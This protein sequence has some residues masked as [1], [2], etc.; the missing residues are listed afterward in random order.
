MFSDVK[1][2]Y[3]TKISCILLFHNLLEKRRV[4]FREKWYDHKTKQR[5]KFNDLVSHMFNLDFPRNSI[6]KSSDNK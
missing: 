6:V 3:C 4:D 5:Y 2:L 1:A